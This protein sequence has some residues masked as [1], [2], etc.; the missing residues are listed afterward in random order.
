MV[1]ASRSASYPGAAIA[2]SYDFG[3][4]DFDTQGLRICRCG[5]CRLCGNFFP[6]GSVLSVI[7]V[8]IR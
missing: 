1:Q 4:I 8:T 5:N 3:S 2:S 7:S 6:W